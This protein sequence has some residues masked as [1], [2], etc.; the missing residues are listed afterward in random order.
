MI[1]PCQTPIALFSITE[2]QNTMTCQS[3]EHQQSLKATTLL[4]ECPTSC[5]KSL[6]VDASGVRVYG[7]SLRDL[8]H[9]RVAQQ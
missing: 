6:S 9:I 8:G 2:V 7:S 1:A 3:N 5:Q 4:G